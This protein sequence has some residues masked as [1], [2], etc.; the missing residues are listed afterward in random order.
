MDWIRLI[1]RLRLP[2]IGWNYLPGG[3]RIRAQNFRRNPVSLLT[4]VLLL[5]S[6]SSLLAGS[7]R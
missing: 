4:V 6:F 3:E 2:Q 5:S 1:T 7:R